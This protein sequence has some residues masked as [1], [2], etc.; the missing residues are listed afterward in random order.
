MKETR[1]VLKDHFQKGA[2]PT[3]VH[4]ENLIDS[5]LNQVDDGVSKSEGCPHQA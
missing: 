2:T 4:F 5:L 3:Q 1:G